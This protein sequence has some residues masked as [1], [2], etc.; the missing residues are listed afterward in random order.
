MSKMN[1]PIFKIRTISP[2]T[3]IHCVSNPVNVLIIVNDKED[4][5]A[6]RNF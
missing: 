2:D 6:L 1:V 5:L 4:H 3:E